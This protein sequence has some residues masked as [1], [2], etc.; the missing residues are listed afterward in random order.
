MAGKSVNPKELTEEQWQH[1]YEL[2]T[3]HQRI[4]FCRYLLW[5]KEQKEEK[6]FRN[7]EEREAKK[8][9]RERIHQ[10]RDVNQHMVYGLGHNSL[11]VRITGRTINKCLDRK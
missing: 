4:K 9:N 8:G 1:L 2:E 3:K 10:E 6:K 11:H 5:K 7:Q